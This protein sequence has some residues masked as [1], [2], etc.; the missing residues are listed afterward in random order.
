MPHHW[1]LTVH[2]SPERGPFKDL[3][4]PQKPVPAPGHRGGK[5]RAMVME[6]SAEWLAL[7]V[8]VLGME[9]VSGRKLLPC[10][11]HPRGYSV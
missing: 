4:D 9:E 10:P 8:A 2:R 7:L 5:P 11:S 1:A 6:E 3:Q